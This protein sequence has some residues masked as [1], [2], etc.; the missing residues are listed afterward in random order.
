VWR[1]WFAK[2]NAVE[3]E[4]VVDWLV[5]EG[6]MSRWR[7]DG[8]RPTWGPCP[9]PSCRPYLHRTD[10]PGEPLPRTH[11]GSVRVVPG[12]AV[13]CFRCSEENRPAGYSTVD[14][15][16]WHT[17]GCPYDRHRHR[18]S[19]LRAVAEA[20]RDAFGVTPPEEGD[21]VVGRRRMP[22]RPRPAQPAT[23]R[24]PEPPPPS[25]PPAEEVD[26][27]RKACQSV[28]QDVGVAGWLKGRGIDPAA[29]AERRLAAAL[30]PDAPTPAWA[31]FKREP[32]SATGHRLL[33]L[34]FDAAGLIRSVLARR[35]V[36]GDRRYKSWAPRGFERRGLVMADASA[37]ALLRGE[38]PAREL[39][40]VI[41]EGEPSWLAWATACPAPD[42]SEL[43][44]FGIVSG[45]WTPDIA[46][47]IPDG[48]TV[49]IATDVGDESGQGDK[50]ADQIKRS[51]GRR[52]MRLERWQ[53]P[54]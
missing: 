41:A 47:R 38:T 39:R 8:G 3:P 7:N 51:F 23:P 54:K 25:Y 22:R 19:D 32:W 11:R 45:S 48:A 29:V 13:V 10:A 42:G 24:R 4:R 26:A 31:S 5:R 18:A 14:L 35:V 36:D 27:F 21:T 6:Q 33:V 44:V 17:L 43:A 12:G 46:A 30:P 53:L 9:E 20:F 1:D 28:V 40:V 2:A 15:V 16:S 49:V 52:N 50:Y 37:R 34:L